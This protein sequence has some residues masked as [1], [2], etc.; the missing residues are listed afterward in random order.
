MALSN[1]ARNLRM[2]LDIPKHCK[3]KKK[4]QKKTVLKMGSLILGKV[5]V[6]VHE[7]SLEK[8]SLK[9]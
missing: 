1:F 9:K 6:L 5:A 7:I 2:F 4:F 8:K 3:A